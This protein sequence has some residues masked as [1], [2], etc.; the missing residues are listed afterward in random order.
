MIMLDWKMA[1]THKIELGSEV[2]H[3]IKTKLFYEIQEY[4]KS[5]PII[6]FTRHV[7][8]MLQEFDEVLK[9]NRSLYE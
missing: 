5:S 6:D 7:D 8:A 9:C 1:Y 2:R 3:K 4:F